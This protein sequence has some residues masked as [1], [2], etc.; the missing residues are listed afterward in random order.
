MVQAQEPGSIP[1]IPILPMRRYSPIHFLKHP[2]EIW[3][4]LLY[5][6]RKCIWEG[7]DM[8]CERCNIEMKKEKINMHIGYR[9]EKRF[10]NGG[11]YQEP[12]TAKSVYIC[13][14]C[15]KIEINIYE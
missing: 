11:V 8:K 12:I 13:P 5:D 10:S 1:G 2:V 7:I 15:G 9:E 3:G 4:V 6:K 14:E